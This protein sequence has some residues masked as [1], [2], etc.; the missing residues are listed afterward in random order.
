ML[1][2]YKYL[3]IGSGIAGTTAADAIRQ[4]DKKG[5]LAILG[6]EPHRLYSRIVLSKPEFYE[7]SGAP[8]TLFLKDLGWYP[9]NG[10]DLLC[11]ET[12]IGLDVGDNRISLASGK[13]IGYEKLLLSIGVQPNPLPDLEP[14]EA[15]NI[16]YLHNLDQANT[17]LE[18][19][20]G[21]ETVLVV[22]GGFIAIELCDLLTKLDKKVISVI[23]SP[24]Y[25][26]STFDETSS[27]FIKDAL[28]R[29][30]I[31]IHTDSFIMQTKGKSK[32]EAAIIRNKQT[33]EETTVPCTTVIA[34]IGT[35]CAL[36]WVKE[37]GIDCN[38]GILTDERLK[39][40]VPNIWAA[41]DCAEYFDLISGRHI[42]LA[43]WTNSR[44]HGKI[45]GVNMIGESSSY[46]KT[47]FY[48]TEKLGLAISFVGDTSRLGKDK[49]TI[50]RGSYESHAYA[51]LRVRG[52]RIIGATMINMANEL[53]SIVS[54]IENEIPMGK[55]LKEIRDPHFD[56]KSLLTHEN[57]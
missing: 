7:K 52:G 14:A 8:N 38:I 57:K 9:R 12:V 21:R 17:I 1:T 16:L 6:N 15:R 35:H 40:N 27:R 19:I 54:L 53:S 29:N 42:K 31:T 11:G 2:H 28:T 22:G 41:G 39:T 37:A 43:N 32:I 55:H 25:W 46:R 26:R 36:D 47:T 56:L 18:N 50:S 34:A 20:R 49:R 10:I 4:H 51:E 23:S 48:S 45:A 5:T 30:G 13:I 3:I 33:G 44:A 24:R